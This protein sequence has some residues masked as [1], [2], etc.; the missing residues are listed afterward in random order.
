M[1]FFESCLFFS[2]NQLARHMNRIADESFKE[3]NITP[4]QGFTLIAIGELDKHTPSEIA[5]ELEM[6]PSTI[7][8]FLDK[9]ENLGYIKRTY[10]GRTAKVDLTDSGSV[11]LKEIF[12]C[13]KDIDFKISETLGDDKALTSKIVEA[14]HHYI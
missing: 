10:Q 4:T 1:S 5:A 13:W 7:T 9:L 12:E 11:L 8:R 3:L 6:K 14:N 2:A